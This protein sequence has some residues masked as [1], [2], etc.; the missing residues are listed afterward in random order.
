EIKELLSIISRGHM[1]KLNYLEK[2]GLLS[3]NNDG[4]YI[5]SGGYGFT[6]ELPQNDFNGRVRCCDMW[7]FTE[8]QETVNVSPEMYEE[9]IFPCEKP[10]MDRFGLTC[11]GCCEPV[12]SRWDIVKRHH[13]LR[14]ISCSPW[15]D[16]EKMAEYLQD[17]YIFS[18]KPNPAVLAEPVINEEAIRA[19]L[20]KAFEVTK[21]CVVE[22]MMKDNH[23]IGKN[24]ENVARWCMIAGE[25]A[26]KIV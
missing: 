26:E 10:I 7:G 6:D 25:E 16:Y 9:F 3:L 12:D 8:S 4:T 24:P 17:R 20:R 23:T 14:R 18:M 19:G 5:G 1:D 21:G 15:A 22:V 11:Y 13:N 2:N